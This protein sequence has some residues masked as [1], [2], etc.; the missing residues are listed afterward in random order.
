MGGVVSWVTDDVLG[1][2]DSGGLVGSVKKLGENFEDIVRE[3]VDEIDAAIQNPYVQLTAQIFFPQYAPFL[4]AYAT[5]DSG[6]EL[7]PSQIASMAAAGYDINTGEPLPADVKKA[8]NTSVA[9]AEGGDP[10]KVL[11]S[12]YGEDFLETSGIKQAGQN[13]ISQ[14]VGSDAYN[15]IKD[16][17]DVARVGYDVLVEG[18]DPS[19][20]IANRYGSQIVGYLGSDDPSINALGY[21]GLAT[22]VQLDKGKDPESALLIGAKQYYDRG[23]QAPDLKNLV[24]ITGI[25]FDLSK[26]GDSNF[27]KNLSKNLTGQLPDPAFVEDYIRQYSPYIEDTVRTAL[28]V[29]PDIRVPEGQRVPFNFLQNVGVPD[30]AFIEDYLREQAEPLAEIEDDLREYLGKLDFSGFSTVDLGINLGD[31]EGLNIDVNELNINPEL[32]A[33]VGAMAK[34]NVPG[35]LVSED[36]EVFASLEPDLDFLGDSN[37]PFSRQV[38][39]RTV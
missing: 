7:S 5:L 9:L 12:A 21:A 10:L 1:I 31:L 29:L 32:R 33:L 4:D 36:G 19:E 37:T 2:D 26:L 14:A 34:E 8:L 28:D 20:A 35:D 15:L 27:L 17:M 13:A 38:L 39:E 6:E 24:D 25:P 23:G 30:I 3:G 22:A 11:V 16:N 18:K